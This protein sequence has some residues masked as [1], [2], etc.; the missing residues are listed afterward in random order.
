MRTWIGSL[1]L[2]TLVVMTA[3]SRPAPAQDY[4]ETECFGRYGHDVHHHT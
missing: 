1:M 4:L 2:G 3:V